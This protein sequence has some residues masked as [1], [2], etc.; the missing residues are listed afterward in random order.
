MLGK[1]SARHLPEAANNDKAG[2][3]TASILD[4]TIHS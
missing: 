1:E 2:N 4:E 3:I